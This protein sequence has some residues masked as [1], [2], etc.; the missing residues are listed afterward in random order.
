MAHTKQ[1]RKRIRQAAARQEANTM[2]R[3]RMR[4]AIKAFEAKLA[5]GDKTGIADTFKTAMA[6]LA[7]AARHGLISKGAAARKTSRLA[8]RINKA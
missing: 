4:T 7:K 2:K 5:E 3:T 6:Q 1:A 8:A